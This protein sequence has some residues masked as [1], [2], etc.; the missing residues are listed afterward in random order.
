[1][2][3]IAGIFSATSEAERAI[4]QLATAGFPREHLVMLAPG[5]DARPLEAVPTEDA[6]QPGMGKAIGSVVGGA[7]G[8]AGG[9]AISSLILPGVGPIVAIGIGAAAL[10]LGGAVAGGVTGQAL[11]DALS[12]GL[13]RDEVFFYEDALR[14]GRSV[15]VVSAEDQQ[16]SEEA[17]S[18]MEQNGAESLDAAR[19]RWWIG[20]RH[21]GET[22][23]GAG[24]E[25]GGNEELL[26][27]CGF[28]AA[29]EP[30]LRGR[31][32]EE[33]EPVVRDRYPNFCD[34]EPFRRGYARGQEHWT[35]ISGASASQEQ[36]RL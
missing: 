11:E 2:I 5:T 32:L 26:Y 18:I 25:N 30:G 15:V 35:R 4:E 1:M 10:G 20:L 14:Q 19:E 24:G 7:A 22:Q 28:E 13:P 12:H 21:A 9:A 17:R 16:Q 3:T 33:A 31:S 29:L 8:M 36:R 23:Y 27:R 34:R 6:E